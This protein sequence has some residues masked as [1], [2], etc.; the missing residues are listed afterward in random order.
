MSTKHSINLSIS[1]FYFSNR[2][3]MKSKR[4]VVFSDYILINVIGFRPELYQMTCI[5]NTVARGYWLN[6]FSFMFKIKNYFK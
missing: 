3:I 5:G 4:Q 1:I 2:V 6:C